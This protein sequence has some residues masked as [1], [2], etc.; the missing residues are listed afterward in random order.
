MFEW[1]EGSWM[2]RCRTSINAT[3]RQIPRTTPTLVMSHSSALDAHPWSEQRWINDWRTQPRDSKRVRWPG[4]LPHRKRASR[5]SEPRRTH[6][7]RSFRRPARCSG[8]SRETASG[9]CWRWP[10][11]CS[12][13]NGPSNHSTPSTERASTQVQFG[14]HYGASSELRSLKLDLINQLLFN[15]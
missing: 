10:G 1:T 4:L 11:Y 5:V 3:P 15:S 7:R 8:R 2:N 9:S 14:G 13:P 6:S 12:S